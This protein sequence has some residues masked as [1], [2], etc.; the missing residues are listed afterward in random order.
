MDKS[1]SKGMGG[2][3]TRI[4]L[5]YVSWR[6][7][8]F[9][10]LGEGIRVIKRDEKGQ[11]LEKQNNGGAFAS[12]KQM[13]E[14]VSQMLREGRQIRAEKGLCWSF[15]CFLQSLRSHCQWPWAERQGRKEGDKKSQCTERL[16]KVDCKII[17]PT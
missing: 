15:S 13:E 11:Q 5:R 12:R 14:V 8:T 7:S 10:R 3:E 1:Q 16:S 2:R 17:S 6:M 9:L 4:G